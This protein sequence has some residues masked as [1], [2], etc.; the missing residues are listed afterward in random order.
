MNDEAVLEQF[1]TR[2][3]A[4][5]ALACRLLGST[6]E[7]DDAVQE[8]WLRVAVADTRAVRNPQ[9][10]LTTVVSRIC[11]DMLRSRAVRRE[12]SLDQLTGLDE[13][14]H[15]DPERDAVLVDAVGRA[16]LVVLDTLGP[17]ERVAF[18]L[19]DLFAVPFA[20]IAPIIGRTPG[21]AK[22]L[23]SR[24]RLRARG[25]TARPAAGLTAEREV[26]SAFLAAA[27]G[28]DLAELLAV[29]APDV[30]RTADTAALPAGV[31]TVVRGARAVAEET[32]LLRARSQ[33]AVPMLVDGRVGIVVAPG[34]RAVSVLAVT[35]REQRVA[36]YEVIAD[37]RRLAQLRLAPLP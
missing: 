4:L 36:A 21:T 24:A 23:A 15:S 35:V 8:A 32:V 33:V 16:L 13:Q 31:A 27:R 18:V 19:H 5:H 20:Q 37:P 12:Y 3:P 10:W 11:L 28:G 26:V 29:L 25:D 6:G 7:A 17:E 9:A 1:A 2:R 14:D 34:G 30:V 22:K